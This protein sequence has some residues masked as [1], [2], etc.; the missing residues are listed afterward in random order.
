MTDDGRPDHRHHRDRPVRPGGDAAAVARWPPRRRPARRG[1]PV[2]RRSPRWA[3]C[4]GAGAAL[5]FPMGMSAAADDPVWSAP[6]VGV[7]ASIGYVAFL[8]GPPLVGFVADGVGVRRAVGVVLVAPGRHGRP[9]AGRAA[10]GAQRTGGTTV[11]QRERRRRLDLLKLEVRRELLAAAEGQVAEHLLQLGHVARH[12]ASAG[13]PSRRPPGRP[14]SPAACRGA[15]PRSVA[16]WPAGRAGS[17]SRRRRPAARTRRRRVQPGAD[18]PDHP[19]L[20]QPPD[21]VQ[22]RRG[23]RPDRPG[24]LHVRDVGIRL[25]EV[26]S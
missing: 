6:R 12:H 26:S 23:D 25:E 16:G 1:R 5:G 13:S 11:A 21:P 20:L 18:R 7:V 14:R 4:S 9:G 15:C 24:Q 2:G 22:G 8:A 19:G 17:A 3:A 10:A